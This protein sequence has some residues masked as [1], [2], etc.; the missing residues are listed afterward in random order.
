MAI[1][2][3]IQV[4][5]GTVK[6]TVGGSQAN[7]AV[8]GPIVIDGSG[9]QSGMQ[10]QS[11]Q[12]GSGPAAPPGNTGGSGPAAPPGNTGGSGPAAPPGNTGGG[13]HGSG[14]GSGSSAPVVIGPIVITGSGLGA[15][16]S[17]ASMG[18]KAVTVNPPA[19][20]DELI[21]HKL[22][23][24]TMQPQQE[25]NWCWAALA[26]SINDFLDPESDPTWTQAKL[27]TQLLID[28]G[29]KSPGCID[30]PKSRICNRP[31][32]LDVALAITEN[33]RQSGAMFNQHLTFDCIQ[34][35]V[36]ARFPV[37]ARIVWWDGGAHFVAL[38]GCKVTASGHRLV[39]VQDPND[40]PTSS[41]GFLDY[42]TLVEDYGEAGYWN[43]TYLVIQ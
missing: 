21:K 27:A 14:S 37:G 8:I 3:D 41:P 18:S 39:H 25:T 38:D 20:T 30:R 7:A 24:F 15:A 1:E 26:V 43:D 12:G 19:P 40:N 33:L 10:G 42:D 32:A 13:G 28:Q 9:M 34:N 11:G 29:I 4:V 17:G 36:K 16:S 23:A 6:I 2:F 31:E 5:N 35:W 22:P